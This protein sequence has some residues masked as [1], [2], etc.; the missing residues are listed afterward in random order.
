MITL[1]ACLHILNSSI[2]SSYPSPLSLSSPRSGWILSYAKDLRVRWLR[3][4]RGAGPT[5]PSRRCRLLCRTNGHQTGSRVEPMA[6]HRG[7]S[8]VREGKDSN[9]MDLIHHPQKKTRPTI[10][11]RLNLTAR[12][13]WLIAKSFT[14]HYDSFFLSISGISVDFL[15][16]YQATLSSRSSGSRLLHRTLPPAGTV[17]GRADGGC[18]VRRQVWHSLSGEY[19]CN[20]VLL[21][22]NRW[23][24]NTP[25]VRQSIHSSW[26]NYSS[27]DRRLVCLLAKQAGRILLT[28]GKVPCWRAVCTSAWHGI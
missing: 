8:P 25:T 11:L 28:I 15:K 10:R 17:A 19:R 23:W 1:H 7:M 13:S 12:G 27:S 16:R 6:T 21:V 14:Y 2:N 24:F 3:P 4:V 26:T 22:S 9:L 5:R 20:A 18:A